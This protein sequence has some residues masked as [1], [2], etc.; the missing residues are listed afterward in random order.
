LVYC[1]P[2]ILEDLKNKIRSYTKVSDADLDYSLQFYEELNFL[3]GDVLVRPGNYVKWFYFLQ[4]GCI[5]YYIQDESGTKVMEF[6]TEGEFFTDLY[7]YIEEIPSAS[8]LSATEDCTVY[9]ILKED[10]QKSFDHSH[11]LERFGRLSMQVAFA[12]MCRRNNHLKNLSNQE[13]YLRLLQKRPDLF[14]RVPQYLIASYLGLTP[15][16]LSKIRKRLVTM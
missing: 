3:K 10:V 11:D 16:G 7:A 15:V 9:A 6:F 14:Q 8:Y 12:E 5:C 13:R 1:N 2:G 4:K